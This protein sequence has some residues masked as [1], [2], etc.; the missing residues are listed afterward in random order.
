M[1]T[2]KCLWKLGASAPRYSGWPPWIA[3]DGGDV[4]NHPSYYND[5]VEAYICADVLGLSLDFWRIEPPGTFYAIE[6][7]VD[8]LAEERRGP[9]P[10]TTFEFVL[11][12]GRVAEIIATAI[13][14]AKQL[15]AVEGKATL[16]FAFRWTKLKNRH[17]STWAHPNRNLYSRSPA[18]E[19]R[20]TRTCVIPVGTEISALAPYVHQIIDPV[21][22]LFDGTELEPRVIDQIV[23]ERLKH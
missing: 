8:D 4:A 11:E 16:S 2:E 13:S 22:A 3:L 21:L 18:K 20:T 19:N 14:F 7:M 17:L 1:P 15:N 12:A 23:D 5:A 9:K 10:G 6:G